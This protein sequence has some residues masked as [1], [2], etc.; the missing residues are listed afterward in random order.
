M[1]QSFAHTDSHK[2]NM[3]LNH[4]LSSNIKK[5]SLLVHLQQY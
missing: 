5:L 3:I 2:M 4:I 1:V